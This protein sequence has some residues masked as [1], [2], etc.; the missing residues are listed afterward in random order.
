MPKMNGLE[1]LEKLQKNRIEQTVIIVS[2]VA[3]QGAKETI[4]ALE[5]GAFDFVTKPENYLETKGNDFKS[6]IHAMLDV[7][8]EGKMKTSSKP[9]LTLKSD[10]VKAAARDVETIMQLWNLEERHKN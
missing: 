7:A 8:T 1:L 6:K 9:L 4:R 3:K 2:T 10:T 5:L